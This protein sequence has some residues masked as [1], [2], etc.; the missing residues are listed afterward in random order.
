MTERLNS[1]V[2]ILFGI[3]N[4]LFRTLFA[5]LPQFVK[6][7]DSFAKAQLPPN[8]YELY[9]S[10]D[11]RDRDHACRV[12]EYLLKEKPDASKSLVAA[13][14]LHDIGKAEG[15]YRSFE[16]ILV[17]LYMPKKL[18]KTP[19]YK[20]LKGMWQKR[21]HHAYYGAERLRTAGISEAIAS[22]VEQHH[23]PQSSAEAEQLKSIEDRF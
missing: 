9:L 13:A 4:L 8:A 11:K 12:T 23:N 21:Q 16:R 10:M 3:K 7:N 1:S 19:R 17:H 14:L 22:I 5:F 6:P 15:P 18:T 20:G 2:L